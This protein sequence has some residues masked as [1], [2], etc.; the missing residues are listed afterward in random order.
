[1]SRDHTS[2]NP[3]LD[4]TYGHGYPVQFPLQG[5]ARPF[6]QTGHAPDRNNYGAVAQLP[7]LASSPS[8][9]PFPSATPFQSFYPAVFARATR[10]ADSVEEMFSSSSET[11]R[12]E[13]GSSSQSEE[14]GAKPSQSK[15]S[16][17]QASVLVEEWK[18][19][20]EEV[21][22]SRSL[23]AWQ[24]IVKAVNKAGPLKTMKQCKDKLRN[25]KQ[26]YK[27]AK[28]NNSQTGRAAKTSPFFD[29]FEEVLGSRPV[30]K[31]PGLLQSCSE[32]TTSN[33]PS[34]S[35]SSHADSSD[36]DGD[37]DSS[38]K[39]GK[40]KRKKAKADEPA[41]KKARKSKESNQNAFI[42]L[43][44]KIL[45]M[46]NAQVEAIERSQTRAEELMLKMEIEQRKIDEESR[47][48]DQEFFLRMAE[49]LK[50]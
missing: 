28:T 29:V 21:E 40:N 19:R 14:N 6:R 27:D 34:S 25:L 49:L 16:D 48:R 50:K 7:D 1:M 46:Q 9:A 4:S 38:P 12:P 35:K 37:A 36:S 20:V 15:W 47:R 11:C 17:T 33:S 42:E 5:D 32:S 10:D 41:Q 26:A 2:P 45:E 44:S 22:S 8:P 39:E 31:M 24:R 13:A 3:F 43:S 23:D 30:V 18:E